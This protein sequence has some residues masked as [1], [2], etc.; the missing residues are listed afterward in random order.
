MNYCDKISY[1]IFKAPYSND[2]GVMV[3]NLLSQ[4]P[5]GTNVV[6]LVFF[7][8][9]KNNIDYVENRN[10][11]VESVS[12]KFGKNE[13]VVGLVAQPPLDCG[14]VIEVH[15]IELD[16]DDV[17]TY[18]EFENNRYVI[19]E[20]D[21]VRLLF[22]GAFQSD[23]NIDLYKQSKSVFMQIQGLLDMEKFSVNSIVR[24]WNYIERIT[25]YDGEDQ[26]YQMFNNARSE[27]YSTVEW[28]D[29][30]PAATGIGCDNGGILVDFDAVL[31]KTDTCFAT[32]IDNK[33]QVA[34]HEYSGKVLL[35]AGRSKTTPKFERAKS[36]T[37]EQ[38]RIVYIS[39]TA[40]I[41]GEESL[42]GIGIKRQ[43]EITLENID[44][45]IGN[46]KVYLYRVYLK[47]SD[48]FKIVKKYFDETY[49]N[50]QVSYLLTDVCRDELLIEI[51]GIASE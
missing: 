49:P 46:A 29:G 34:A 1:S 17:L 32:P 35:E 13:P 45:L 23:L 26:H 16:T 9:P 33:L 28:T 19:L 31:F 42:F 38:R 39:G 47:N 15:S 48:D 36:M 5:E 25:C 27:F 30:Y 41:R 14:L 44:Q 3:N 6:R 51:E 8:S 18:K 4:I 12:R 2:F 20:N 37:F 11:I 21:S 7:G 43:L 40:A 10:H 50:L 22:A 24:Q